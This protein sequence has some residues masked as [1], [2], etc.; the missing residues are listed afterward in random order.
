MTSEQKYE[1]KGDSATS[2]QTN[3]SNIESTVN[4]SLSAAQSD[5]QADKPTDQKDYGVPGLVKFFNKYPSLTDLHKKMLA[6]LYADGESMQVVKKAAQ[7]L[8]GS[9][10]YDANADKPHADGFSVKELWAI[11][12]T[13]SLDESDMDML[14]SLFESGCN[15]EV[16]MDK[17]KKLSTLSEVNTDPEPLRL[18][19]PTVAPLTSDQLSDEDFINWLTATHELAPDDFC[20]IAGMVQRGLPRDLVERTAKRFGEYP[21]EK[22][23]VSHTL[24]V[25]PAPMPQGGLSAKLDILVNARFGTSQANVLIFALTEYQ[26]SRLK[27]A[28]KSLAEG[29][30][31]DAADELSD[32]ESAGTILTELALSLSKQA[33]KN[34]WAIGG[35]TPQGNSKPSSVFESYAKHYFGFSDERIQ[36]HVN[37]NY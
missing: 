16:I 23:V 29:L 19:I 32:A 21:P 36:Q 35:Q 28:M 20:T 10:E 33:D 2:T 30:Y 25:E 12:D 15:S 14:F 4:S 13:Y 8:L 24:P 22:R 17:A 37:E 1:G 34:Y 5:Q 18:T 26:D 7:L 9:E 31:D 11:Q 27:S 6:G 3:G